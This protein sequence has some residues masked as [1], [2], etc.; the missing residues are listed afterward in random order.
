LVAENATVPSAGANGA[1]EHEFTEQGVNN[2]VAV[3]KPPSAVQV[4]SPL[5]EYPT[6]HTTAT[7]PVVVLV[8]VPPL[9]LSLSLLAT[10][11]E[12]QV[13]AA[14]GVNNNVAVSKLPS[15]VQVASPLP[16]YPSLHTTATVPVVVLVP[17]PPL[18]LS[19][20]LLATSIESQVAA[21]QPV[22]APLRYV[23]EPV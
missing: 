8:P 19:L 6:S 10:S 16:E 1:A 23:T 2:N 21:T 7:I 5:P 12:S 14:Q 22:G 11:I 3:S 18:A 15:A 4:A 17:V 9:A 13:A 20:S